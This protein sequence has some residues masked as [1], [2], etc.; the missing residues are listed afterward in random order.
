MG[1]VLKD[2]EAA[3]EYRPSG[4]LF[5]R[6]AAKC[7]LSF[8]DE[9]MMGDVG[10]NWSLCLTIADGRGGPSAEGRCIFWGHTAMDRHPVRQAFIGS[11]MSM[12]PFPILIFL[13]RYLNPIRFNVHRS[14]ILMPYSLLLMLWIH[15][16]AREESF[17]LALQ[18]YHVQYQSLVKCPPVTHVV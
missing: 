12:M 5:G 8:E 11:E 10:T 17:Y 7:N 15:A 3:G 4:Y 6:A 18:I 9:T 2:Q 16:R 14:S 1:M 13:S